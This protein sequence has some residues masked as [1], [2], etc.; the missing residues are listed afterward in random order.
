MV[1]HKHGAMLYDGVCTLVAEH[2]EN[3]AKERLVVVFPTGASQDSTHEIQ[4][5]EILLKALKNVWDDHVSSMQKLSQILKY[6][7]CAFSI[8][9]N[10]FSYLFLFNRIGFTRNQPMYLKFGMRVLIFSSFISFALQ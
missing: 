9:H 6:M 1:L 3:L 2:L 8:A 5:A 7:V 10:T 4:E